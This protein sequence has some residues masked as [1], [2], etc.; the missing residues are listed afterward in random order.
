MKARVL[1]LLKSK[2]WGLRF[3]SGEA[4]GALTQEVDQQARTREFAS[5]RDRHNF[6]RMFHP[7]FPEPFDKDALEVDD[8]EHAI[9]DERTV[10]IQASELGDDA[11]DGKVTVLGDYINHHAKE[12]LPS[13]LPKSEKK[14]ARC[15]FDRRRSGDPSALSPAESS[16][17][18]PGRGRLPT[19]A[20]A[21]RACGAAARM[22]R[23]RSRQSHGL[24]LL[25]DHQ[26]RIQLL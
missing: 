12:G 15:G 11:Y 23:L 5:R 6:H 18:Q 2:H 20:A 22:R 13:T 25:P 4:N 19:P 7:G 1:L 14:Q 10:R 9:A 8:M 26:H 24:R 3:C 16:A 21:S 17:R